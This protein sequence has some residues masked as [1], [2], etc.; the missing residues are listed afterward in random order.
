M[1]YEVITV[2]AKLNA[3]LTATLTQPHWAKPE[4]ISD[5]KLS[6]H[7]TVHYIMLNSHDTYYGK[8]V[9]REVLEGDLSQDFT[10]NEESE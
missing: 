6:Y 3:F 9:T 1:L 2:L 8:K 5:E 10:D 4:L 7:A